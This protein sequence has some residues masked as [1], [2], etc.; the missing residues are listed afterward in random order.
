MQRD[1]KL[2]G[3]EY[4][5]LKSLLKLLDYVNSGG[6]AKIRILNGE[7]YVNG[8]EELRRGRKLRENDVVAL[9]GDE[10]RILS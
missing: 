1:F 10:I 4:V 2:D 8:S 9:D 5:E 7:V 6:E 3:H